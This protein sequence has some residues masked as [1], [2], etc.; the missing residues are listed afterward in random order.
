MK[1]I[2]SM[3]LIIAVLVTT[4]LV[5]PT[6]SASPTKKDCTN[7]V[8]VSSYDEL[9][10]ELEKTDSSDKTIVLTKN[11]FV[12]DDVNNL[13]INVANS[14]TVI[15]DLASYDICVTSKSTSEIFCI[16]TPISLHILSTNADNQSDI[17]FY[18]GESF[19][20][21]SMAS[22]FR[23][24]NFN[25]E[26]FTYDI[27]YCFNTTAVNSNLIECTGTTNIFTVDAGNVTISGGYFFNFFSYGSVFEYFEDSQSYDL[28][29]GGNAVLKSGFSP[30]C[31]A[32]NSPQGITLYECTLQLID[33]SAITKP[34]VYDTKE[35]TKTFSDVMG[36]NK[37][38]GEKGTVVDLKLDSNIGISTLLK[39]N[40]NDLKFVPYVS[41]QTYEDT[42][43]LFGTGHLAIDKETGT[44][45][46]VTPHNLEEI[47]GTYKDATCT[48]NGK[49]YDQKCMDC[50]YLIPGAVIKATGHSYEPEHYG[51]ANPKAT[52]K[53]D[54]KFCDRCMECDYIKKISTI[55]KIKTVKL[56][57]TKFVYNGKAQK[58]K[59]TVKNSK[60]ATIPS[61]QYTVKYSNNKKVGKATATVI[62]G[63]RDEDVATLYSG[64]V[65]LSFQIMPKATK[66]SKVTPAK[67]SLK[68]KIKKQTAETTGYQ[69]QYSLKSNMK[70]A[71]IVKIKGA[72]KTSLTIKK[73]KGKKNYYVRVRTYKTVSKKTYYSAWSKVVK[74][75]TKK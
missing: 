12:A 9:K 23:M 57:K 71:K 6:A 49:E 21:W 60:G 66:V 35:G 32:G 69:V 13:S 26:V 63:S 68:V 74:A 56:S 38:T 44:Y 27:D 50:D 2:L 29:V 40:T 31:Y 73:L 28:V 14:G 54:G 59:V 42:D 55:Y 30:I 10:K 58:P 20:N 62:F 53:A 3:F 16:N 15:L 46:L 5:V 64:T 67:K 65:K 7:T 51:F 37:I 48:V 11:I 18:T 70:S 43:I 41:E 8:K 75:K 25:A 17:N 34:R 24:K 33:P 36:L 45:S 52:L 72:K 1:K 61:I 47:D 4:I 39:T 19:S 22:V